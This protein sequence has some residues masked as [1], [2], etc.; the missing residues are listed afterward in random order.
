MIA[1]TGETLK[2]RGV[3]LLGGVGSTGLAVTVDVFRNDTRI[4]AAVAATELDA[5]DAPGVYQ[6]S[7]AGASVTVAGEYLF[8][9]LDTG[10]TSDQ[11]DVYAQWYVRPWL[12]NLV[13][14][15]WNHSR[16]TLTM[17]AALFKSM[18]RGQMLEL[19]RGDTLDLDITG[20]GDLTTVDDLWFT[21]K[22]Q[23]GDVDASAEMQISLLGGLLAIAGATAA[24]PANGSITIT[25]AA[26]GNI[27]VALT[28][29]E[30]AKLDVDFV[31]HWDVQSLT[32][33][34]VVTR[35]RG[36]ARI[37]GDSTRRIV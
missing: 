2:G 14:N 18:L 37:L 16:R 17:A 35:T 19:Q 26:A 5:A 8:H 28:A 23:L 3:F 27:T 12:V 1:N 4:I 31:G 25:D 34:T 7:L 15:I 13:A 29:E 36:N 9:F 11:V 21:L 20:L 32:G 22:K 10:G 33:V 30:M 6:Y 24:T